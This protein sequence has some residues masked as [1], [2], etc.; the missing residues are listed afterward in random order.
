[1]KII[2][3]LV[4]AS[5]AIVMLNAAPAV[6]MHAAETEEVTV[7]ATVTYDYQEAFI[8]ALMNNQNTWSNSQYDCF[9]FTDLDW[10]GRLELIC[11]FKTSGSS[12][13]L[14]GNKRTQLSPS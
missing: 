3:K 1:M 6:S 11:D 7:G 5:L 13:P 10:D 12:A 4:S 9:Y 14:V 8:D 2:R